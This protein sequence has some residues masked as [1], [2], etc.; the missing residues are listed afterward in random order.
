MVAKDQAS[1]E[2]GQGIPILFAARWWQQQESNSISEKHASHY[3]AQGRKH[4]V[5][6]GLIRQI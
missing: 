2:A 3:T 6:G 1:R 5:A 4:G